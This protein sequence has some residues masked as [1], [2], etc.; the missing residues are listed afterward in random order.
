ML[1]VSRG[2]LRTCMPARSGEVEI[3]G[4]TSSV[5]CETGWDGAPTRGRTASDD[6]NDD[7]DDDDDENERGIAS[8]G[9]R[10]VRSEIERACWPTRGRAEALILLTSSR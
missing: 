2:P 5:S 3:L 6:G 8:C 4:M 10:G 1:Y 7:D 9:R